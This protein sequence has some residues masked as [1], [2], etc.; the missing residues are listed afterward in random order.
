MDYMERGK[1]HEVITVFQGME[2]QSRK[3]PLPQ[4][5]GHRETREKT[6]PGNANKRPSVILR[7]KPTTDI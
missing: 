2:E 5:K 4:E 1:F 7:G 3:E 6:K